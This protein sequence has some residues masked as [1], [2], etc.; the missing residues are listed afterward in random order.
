MPVG[1]E[2][3]F[4]YD[5]DFLDCLL[6]AKNLYIYRSVLI[7]SYLV[8]GTAMIH[9]RAVPDTITRTHTRSLSCNVHCTIE[10]RTTVVLIFLSYRY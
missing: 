1:F 9:Q 2:K 4:T 8:S 7:G 5:N 10:H 3:A 6:V